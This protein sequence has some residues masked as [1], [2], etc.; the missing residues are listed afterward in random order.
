MVRQLIYSNNMLGKS[1]TTLGR[2]KLVLKNKMQAEKVKK[3]SESS[4][5]RDFLGRTIS[6][7]NMRTAYCI[8]TMV[9]H[10]VGT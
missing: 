5:S 9:V 7:G 6:P 1:R 2:L 3:T 8:S 10:K 4:L